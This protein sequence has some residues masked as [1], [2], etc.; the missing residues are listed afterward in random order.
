VTEGGGPAVEV[1][2]YREGDEPTVIELFSTEFAARAPDRLRWQYLG[3]F[4]SRL[5]LGFAEGEL[6]RVLGDAWFPGYVNGEPAAVGVCGDWIAQNVALNRELA[7]MMAERYFDRTTTYDISLGFP[8]EEAIAVSMKRYQARAFGTMP[9]WVRWHN[10]GAVRASNARIPM[11]LAAL[12]PAATR[13]VASFS[14]LGRGRASPQEV[15]ELDPTLRASLDQLAERTRR[16]AAL[17]RRRDAA[18]LQW[19]WFD[20][21]GRPWRMAITQDASGAVTGM[22]VYGLDLE[23]RDLGRVVDLL[24]L[25]SSTTT[26]L[27]SHA[28]DRLARAG[29]GRTVCEL[30]DGRP[31]VPRAMRRAGFANRGV[32]PEMISVPTPRGAI[33][34]EP[35]SFYL[36]FGDTD[37]C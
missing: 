35:H 29:A 22:V 6:A 21:P 19:R 7:T 32:G 8:R 5:L 14:A 1:R 24:A 25:D 20:Q 33:P 16:I 37:L 34:G 36:T 26:V 28:A 13:A 12:V 15:T 9:Q 2:F 31:W 3:P 11:V 27:V 30:I 18:Y 17:I 23:E 10:A 4:D